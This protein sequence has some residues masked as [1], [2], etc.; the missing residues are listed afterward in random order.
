MKTELVLLHF[1]WTVSRGRETYGY[2]IC[3]LFADGVRVAQCNGGG[4]DMQGT[5]LGEYIQKTYQPELRRVF[6]KQI[7]N[8]VPVNWRKYKKD[9]GTTERCLRKNVHGFY[10]ATLINGEDGK[11][12]VSLNGRC[13]FSSIEKIANSIGIA[14]NWN[15]ESDR[16]KNDSY[17]IAT[18][19]TAR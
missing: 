7:K 9:D 18:Y 12:G 1:K 4:Y 17:Y 8:V 19:T 3:T 2:N 13:G 14:L 15:K 10:G 16:S 6:E 11:I 5:C